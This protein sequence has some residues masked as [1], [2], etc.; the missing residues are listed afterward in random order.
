MLPAN[1]KLGHFNLLKKK[2]RLLYLKIK[3]VPRSKHLEILTLFKEEAQTA[4][5]KDQVC[6]AQ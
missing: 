5:F 6:T 1:P 4:L 2:R 3:S